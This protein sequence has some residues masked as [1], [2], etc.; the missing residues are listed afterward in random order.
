MKL[1]EY[2]EQVVSKL[3]CSRQEKQDTKE[4]L[5][6]HLNSMKLELLAQGYGEA[7]AETMAIQRF[8]SVEQISRQLSESM[9]LVD[10]YI[11]KWLLGLFSLY[12]LAASYLVL[13]SPDRWHR[14]RFTLDWKQR[15]LEYG[16][17]QYTH[18]FQ[19]TKPLHTLKDYFFHTES[20]GLS[21]MLYNLLGNV[22]LFLPL[23]ILVPTLFSSFQS[24]HRVFFTA[25]A[26]SLSIEFLQFWFA[27]GSFDVD[28]L[29]L[30]IVGALLGYLL[31]RSAEW[32]VD[33][34]K[35]KR[36]PEAG[37]SLED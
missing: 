1:E 13:L 36:F 5:L 21:N 25:L 26:A 27:L 34:Q 28:D 11:H 10:K 22:G 8:G 35:K 31:F 29:L 37:L 9:P 3:F 2:A 33:R 23:G 6:D 14:R 30:N 19:N 4:E 15:M 32:F 24:I 18:I 7:D 20:I 17:P 16:V 12:I